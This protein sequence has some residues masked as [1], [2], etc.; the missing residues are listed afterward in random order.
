VPVQFRV[1]R[2]QHQ[3]LEHPHREL[4]RAARAGRA[5]RLSLCRRQQTVQPRQH[6]PHLAC[7]GALCHR[8]APHASGGC[9]VSQ[10]DPDQYP[11]PG[12]DLLEERARPGRPR[13]FLPTDRR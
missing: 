7:R 12:P 3:R 8:D 2:G 1:A 11:A 9:R 6:G 4:E 10:V 5:C 13:A